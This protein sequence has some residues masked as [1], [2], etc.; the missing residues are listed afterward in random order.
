MP[1]LDFPL[2]V[3]KYVRG[4]TGQQSLLLMRQ[5]IIPFVS[6]Y[7]VTPLKLSQDWIPWMFFFFCFLSHTFAARG[8]FVLLVLFFYMQFVIFDLL[9]ISLLICPHLSTDGCVCAGPV[10]CGDP[11]F[12]QFLWKCLHAGSSLAP[13]AAVA[14]LVSLDHRS[15]RRYLA[16]PA[17]GVYISL[18]FT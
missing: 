12:G 11:V 9:Q 4:T 5:L 15:H 14:C 7:R 13:H 1:A 17:C 2:F 8:H 3:G 6:C 10:L 16:H 18:A